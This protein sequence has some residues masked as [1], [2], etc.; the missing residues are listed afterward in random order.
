MDGR[1]VSWEEMR[2]SRLEEERSQTNKPYDNRSVHNLNRRGGGDDDDDNG[3]EKFRL[4]R[5]IKKQV[6]LLREGLEDE[7]S[8]TPRAPVLFKPRT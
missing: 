2:W 8:K 7:D 4:W 3:L 5:E 1:E 6:K